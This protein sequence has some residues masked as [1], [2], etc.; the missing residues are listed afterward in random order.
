MVYDDTY[1]KWVGPAIRAANQNVA[2]LTVG[3]LRWFD[4]LDN[5]G[6][7]PGVIF[8]YKSLWDAGVRLEFRVGGVL[9]NA[10][11]P[12]TTYLGLSGY[13][14]SDGDTTSALVFQGICEVS[15]LGLT[16]THKISPWTLP[17]A[18]S[19]AED[20]LVIVLAC[21]SSSGASNAFFSRAYGEYRWVS[22]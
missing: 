16:A 18:W 22:S 13:E 7:D 15:N 10:N 3:S 11:A 17:T 4:L 20:H 8:G 9:D 5:V 14:F 1:G 12:Q 21:G 19:P 6:G 2:L